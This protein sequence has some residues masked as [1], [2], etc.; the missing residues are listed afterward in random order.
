MLSNFI[1]KYKKVFKSDFDHF[2]ESLKRNEY[3]Y[4]RV[5]TAR[6]VDYLEEFDNL[7]NFEKTKGFPAYRYSKEDSNV[8]KSISFLTGGLYIQNASSLFPPKILSE[9]ISHKHP[10]I[11]DMCA[12]PGGKTTYLSELFKRCGIV[13]ANEISSKRLKA[14]NFNIAKY[15]CFN[16]KTVSMDGRSCGKKFENFFDAVLLDAPCSNE[17]K[18]LKNETVEKLWSEE[19]I[20]NMQKI[21]MSLIDSGFNSLKD[22]GYL[23]YSTCTFSV[24]ENEEVV[25]FL[26]KKYKNAV[27]VDINQNRYSKGISKNDKINERVIRVFP[28]LMQYDGFFIALIQKDGMLTSWDLSENCKGKN[29]NIKVAKELSNVFTDFDFNEILYKKDNKFFLSPILRF[30]DNIFTKIRFKNHDFLVGASQKDFM[31]STE[32]VWEFGSKI[33]EDKKVKLNREES[34]EYLNGF[35]INYKNPVIESGALFLGSIPVGP[36]KVV[37][38]RIKNKIDRYF[39]YNRV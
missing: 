13:F 7:E 34:I 39:I 35:D 9:F 10:V 20:K 31:I 26:L 6:D 2:F 33:I 37:E 23:I 15:G 28:Q 8:S 29:E 16:V 27:L 21:Q 17:N 3:K 18:I 32:G 4:F 38:N 12:A 5:N 36:F 25:E 1:E 14:L 24:E 22:G 11:L 30:Q 19:F